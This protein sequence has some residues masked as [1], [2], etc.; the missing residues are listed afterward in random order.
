MPTV[1]D[2]LIVR[3]GLDAGEFRRGSKVAQDETK[4]TR[5][6]VVK[7]AK[8]IESAGMQAAHFFTKLRNEALALFGLFMAGQGFKTFILNTTAAEAAAGRLAKNIGMSTKELTAWQGAAERAGGSAS[9]TGATFQGLVQGFQQFALT[10]QS[11][12]IPYFRALGVEVSD[13]EGNMRPLK[14]IMLDLADRFSGMSPQRANAFG[15]GLGLDQ[16]TIN[17]LL[18]GRQAVQQLLAEQEKLGTISDEDAKIGE[19]FQKSLMDIQQ[20]MTTLGREIVNVLAPGIKKLLEIWTDWIAKNREW[21]SLEIVKRVTDFAVAAD[22]VATSLG[23]WLKVTEIL[24][25][26]WLGS[27]FLAVLANLTKLVTFLAAI[28]GTGITSAVLARLGIAALPLSLKGDTQKPDGPDPNYNREEESRKVDEWWK[29]R[30]TLSERLGIPGAAPAERRLRDILPRW[31]G[32][33]EPRTAN[34]QLNAT[35]EGFLRTLSG[36]ESHGA[37]NVKNG[38]ATFSSYDQ[39]PEGV[40]PGGTSTAAGR[41][42]FTSGTWEEVAGELGLKDFSPQS[43]DIAAWYLAQREYRQKTGGDLETDLRAGKTAQIAAALKG[44]WPTLPGGSQSKQSQSD[45]DRNLLLNMPDAA[46]TPTPQPPAGQ[47]PFQA[48][49]DRIVPGEPPGRPLSGIDPSLFNNQNLASLGASQSSINNSSET[50][51]NGPITVHTAATDANGIA[52]GLGDAL[53]RYTF[54]TQANTGLA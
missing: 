35:Q 10:G 24:F 46:G 27:K 22:A 42:Q 18:K 5:E 52:R 36:P 3:I 7:S 54:V 31:L 39:F 23:G 21:L 14:D 43:Q 6:I 53:R 44:R 11:S 16:G 48:P 41:Y 17:L 38:G 15:A 40:Y 45:F 34:T 37:Y 2:E 29:S 26:L 13:L 51:I 50:S 1:I 25:G 49:V 20:V 47:R 4:R 9:A 12:T 33:N 28:P 30:P 8:E 19:E 32:G